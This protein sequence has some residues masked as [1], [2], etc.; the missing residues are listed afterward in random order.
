MQRW[1]GRV[2]QVVLGVG[3]FTRQ[4]CSSKDFETLLPAYLGPCA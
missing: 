2:L 1:E 4:L 3:R